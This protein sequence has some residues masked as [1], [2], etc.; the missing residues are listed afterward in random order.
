MASHYLA[1]RRLTPLAL[2]VMLTLSGVDVRAQTPP[3]GAGEGDAA[4]GNP[5]PDEPGQ[6]SR[7]SDT[8]EPEA[9]PAPETSPPPAAGPEGAQPGPSAPEADPSE[10]AGAPLPAPLPQGEAE[11]ASGSEILEIRVTGNRRV[12]SDDI[13][14]YLRLRKGALFSPDA[15]TR[16]VRELWASGFF[17]DVEVDLQRLDGGVALTF[18]VRERP[19]IADITFEGN[20]EISDE[21]LAEAVELKA[22]TVLSQPAVRR[23]IQKIRDLYAERGYFL[24]EVTSEDVP[25]KNNE[26][27]LVFRVTEHNEVTVKRINFIGN[28]SIPESELRAIMFTGNPGV[29][30]WGSGGPFRQDAFERD[31]AMISA[32]YYDKGYLAVTVSQPRVMLTSDRS[33]IELSIHID[34]GPRFKIRQ[35]RIFERGDDGSEVEP[36]EGRRNLRMMVRADPGDYF[37]R[38]ALLED[39]QAV[40]TLYRDNG[41]ANVDASP[42]TRLYPE[43]AEVDVIV[44]V[45]RGPLVHFER[46]EVRGNTK[47]RDKVIRRELEIAETD[48]FSETKLEKSRQRITRLGYFERV[49]ISTEQG[50]TPDTVNVFVEVTERA[51][52]TFQVGAGFSSIENFIV[53]AQ[54][55][56]ANLFGSGQSVSLQ[57]QLSG[58][59]ELINLSWIEPYFLDSD[60]SST[61]SLYKQLRV[62]NDFSQSSEGGALTFG[63]PLIE[64]ELTAS[65]TYT[66]ELDEISTSTTS[67]LLGTTTSD[68]TSVFRRLPLASLFNDGLTSSFRPGLTYDSRDNRLFPTRGVYLSG[69][70]ELASTMFGSENEFWRNRG[71]GRFYYPIWSGVVFKINAEAELVTSPDDLGVPL[72]ARTFLGGILDVRG[73][74]YRS[75]GPRLQIRSALDPN[76]AP[77]S[78][79]A[80][81]GGNLSYFQNLEIEFDILASAGI[82]GVV[83]TDAG[84]AWN[85]EDKYCD[86]TASP[87]PETSPCFDGFDSLRRLRTSYGAGLR[88]FSPLG[89]LRFEWGFPFDPLPYEEDM[90]FEFTI[91]NFF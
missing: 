90:V 85:L 40:R 1:A 65:L 31:I 79:G 4:R 89:P 83:F 64:P 10:A 86:A 60:F 67:T 9:A 88:W 19:A 59:R 56:Q 39:L 24:A 23:T 7:V 61:V 42:Q 41:F 47:T 34:E 43:K 68:Y 8:P 33:G 57:A 21:D 5:A 84:N 55:Q 22:N 44:P 81:I 28:H 36:I 13:L 91:G 63:Y 38:A 76:S 16:D 30:A 71:V 27:S 51:T 62:Y 25:R 58:A 46:I 18:V 66:L 3:P 72:F 54:V 69:S 73:F 82:K 48:K 12:S 6:G 49:D 78:A 80:N 11:K 52:G 17:E 20:D 75:L 70:T 15:L 32:L 37:N 14:T 74:N 53:T 35:L 87:Y 50:S 29:F 77:Y 45:V 26:V 2:S